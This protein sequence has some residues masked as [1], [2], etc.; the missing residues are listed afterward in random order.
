MPTSIDPYP[1]MGEPPP[2]PFGGPEPMPED[3]ELTITGALSSTLRHRRPIALVAAIGGLLVGAL[4]FASGA[5]YTT[6]ASFLPTGSSTSASGLSGIAAQFGVSVPTSEFTLPSQF[7]ADLLQSTWF[8]ER[9]ALR[10][11]KVQ[12][13]DSTVTTNL[14]QLYEIEEDTP[15]EALS[16]AVTMLAEEIIS[17]TTSTETGVVTATI[18]TEWPELS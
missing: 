13:G 12:V 9:I 11:Y 17:V 10:E 2:S 14:I 3:A 18:T 7:Y 1:R 16:E 6:T 4:L 8:L 5:S 15:G